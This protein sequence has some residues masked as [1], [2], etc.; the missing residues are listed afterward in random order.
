M[1]TQKHLR[2]WRGGVGLMDPQIVLVYP[3][4]REK[5]NCKMQ[6]Y[7]HVARTPK[8]WKFWTLWVLQGWCQK[9]KRRPA[10]LKIINCSRREA[11]KKKEGKDHDRFSKKNE[12]LLGANIWTYILLTLLS[13]LLYQFGFSLVCEQGIGYLCELSIYAKQ[14]D[15][16]LKQY[17]DN[18]EQIKKF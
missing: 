6:N 1:T 18:Y 5:C 4:S 16:C 9:T 11:W 8:M 15:Q 12:V 7:R 13:L 14:S 3:W 17:S 10:E 2:R